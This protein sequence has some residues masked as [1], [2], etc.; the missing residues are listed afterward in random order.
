IYNT[1]KASVNFKVFEK[2]GVL[3]NGKKSYEVVG[4]QGDK[5]V[6]IKGVAYKLGNLIFEMGKDDFKNL[7]TGET[8]SLGGDYELT[9]NAIDARAMP[10]QAWLSLRKN[11]TVIDDFIISAPED[12]STAEKQKAVYIKTMT[13]QG[14]SDAL[15]FT[16]YV[17]RIFSGPTSDMVQFKYGWLFDPDSAKEIRAGDVFDSFEV[18]EAT[19]DNIRLTNE[20]LVSLARNSESILLGKIN[21]RIADNDTLRLYPKV[22]YMIPEG[23]IPPVINNV[24]LNTTSPNTGQAILV[25]VNVTGN[26]GVT[27]VEANGAP[28]TVHGGNTFT[29][30][31]IITALAGTHPVNVSASDAAGNVG[32]N[33][34]TSYSAPPIPISGPF[35]LTA[36][37]TTA[38]LN[39]PINVTFTVLYNSTPVSGATVI[40]GGNA[41]GAGTTDSKGTVAINV[42]ATGA[43][44]ITAIV[45]KT[46]YENT[47]FPAILT[48]T[49]PMPS[50][51]GSISGMKFNDLNN[52]SIKD[53]GEPGLAGWSIIL[54]GGSTATMT[55]T[56]GSTATMTTDA[57]GSYTFSNLAQGNYTVAEVI[58]PGWTQT[59]PANGTYDVTIA[60]GENLTGIDFGNN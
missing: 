50:L 33:N 40:L 43:G 19:P 24:T 22:D 45:T 30:S 27:G 20:K 2:E 55:A 6:A 4:W 13:I 31:G 11:G 17:D 28:L 39:V 42:K 1:T 60:G 15:L 58:Q 54:T 10:R 9:A 46:G 35:L 44:A 47:T 48:A 12:N 16:I 52:N 29:W 34:S 56:G 26:V 7:T 57:N 25:T 3:V 5:Y 23:T 18:R 8:W 38:V 14:E 32:W 37:P 53:T 41:T 21:L 51:I 49:L 36:N 59:F